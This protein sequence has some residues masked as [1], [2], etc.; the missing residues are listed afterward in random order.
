[1]EGTDEISA[2]I[3]RWSWG[4]RRTTRKARM[5]LTRR[6]TRSTFTGELLDVVVKNCSTVE[7]TTTTCQRHGE[8]AFSHSI[9]MQ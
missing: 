4:K 3:M 7:P 5:T 6:S 9:M 1:M 8:V 2:R